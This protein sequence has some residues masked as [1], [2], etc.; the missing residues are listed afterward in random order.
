M[1][2]D[3]IRALSYGMPP[4]AV[5]AWASTGWDALD[6]LAYEFAMLIFVSATAAGKAREPRRTQCKI[7]TAFHPDGA[8]QK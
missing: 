8:P 1:D 5:W 3:Y 4:R 6:R 2:E 7:P